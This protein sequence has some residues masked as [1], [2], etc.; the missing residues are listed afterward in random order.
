MEN[1]ENTPTAVS[2][3]AKL[4]R[5][6]NRS[7][8]LLKLLRELKNRTQI[9]EYL[10]N[11]VPD[12]VYEID[13]EGRFIYINDAIRHLGYS[14]R[15]LIGQ[16]FSTI[17]H[18]ADIEYVSRNQVL[19][20]YRGIITGDEK[21]P[22]L[23]DERRTGKRATKNLRLRLVSKV[24]NSLSKIQQ[25]E[26]EGISYC[27][28]MASGYYN[29]KVEEKDKRFLGTLGAIKNIKLTAAGKKDVQE[30][31]PDP[32][33]G[34]EY[35]ASVGIIRDITALKHQDEHRARL[36]E[37]SRQSQKLEAVGRLAGGIAHDFNNILAAISGYTDIIRKKFA[38]DN[39]RLKH[40]SSVI[41]SATM[42]AADLTSKLLAFARRGNY[43][44]IP[45]DLHHAI[46]DAVAAL[47]DSAG[48]SITIVQ[49]LKAEHAGIIGDPYQIRDSLV[50]IALN[51]RD[52]L[53]EGGT[54]TFETD[55]VNP[56]SDFLRDHDY[57]GDK[58][59]FVLVSIK[60][61]GTGMDEATRSRIFEP[62]FTT[63]ELG[64]GTGLGLASVYGTVK[65]HN[66]FIDVQS[67]LNCGTTFNI[68]FPLEKVAPDSTGNLQRQDSPGKLGHVLIIDDEHYICE[69]CREMLTDFGYA[70]TTCDNGTDA[71]S[72][73]EHH[74]AEIDLVIIDMIMPKINGIQCFEQFKDI[75][76]RIKAILSTGYSLD[77][78]AR[79]ILKTGVLGFIRKP[80]TGDD[81]K[82]IVGEVMG[83]QQDG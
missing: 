35:H 37:Q 5:Y 66:G 31:S 27:E 49:D 53:P 19:P 9:T 20:K 72:F 71:I 60:D 34:T 81:L 14:P 83:M 82:K 73:Y 42:R 80:F 18:P 10:L 45:L 24:W 6:K 30:E 16:H 62:F 41:L 74:S 22:K 2:G 50:N 11:V 40:Y 46:K 54:I 44:N 36:E 56:N 58:R 3:S 65:L 68:Y 4:L 52:A 57:H 67:T 12:I 1:P 76:P 61:N 69:I 21:A 55:I 23:F 51:A 29:T 79:E 8:R 28:V 32:A 77:E 48:T 17:V 26:L 15:E 39:P 75:N 25:E 38:Q 78:E 47:Q 13:P 59:T 70:V 33:V 64:K 43:Q 63:K 7:R